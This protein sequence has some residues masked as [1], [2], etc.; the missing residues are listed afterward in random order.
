MPFGVETVLWLM[1]AK[2]SG[3]WYRGIFDAVDRFMTRWHRGETEKSWL[4][5]GAADAMKS[6]NG[7]PGAGGRQP[8]R[9]I[10]IAVDEC[11]NKVASRVARYRFD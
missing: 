10:Y 6:D 5:H 9:Y 7:K 11:R 4:R 8:Y 2:N 3:N 1:V